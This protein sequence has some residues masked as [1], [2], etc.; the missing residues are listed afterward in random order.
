MNNLNSEI[1]KLRGQGLT[2]NFIVDELVKKG[3]PVEQ[4]NMALGQ[5]DFN[6]SQQP[7]SFSLPQAPEGN[8]D[9]RIE[10]IAE[11]I[12]DEKWDQLIV[13]VKKIIDWKE[14]VEEQQQKLLNDLTKL[15]EDFKTL[16]HG[17]L[18]KLE[19]YDSRM[20]EVGTELNAVG[21]VFKDVVPQFVENVKELSSITEK[22]R[23]K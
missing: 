3:Y 20:R 9:S 10:E 8:F 22:V 2:D 23:K 1:E 7:S 16:H 19:D 11:G 4:V 12:I 17:V 14:K 6:F 21:K 18:G 5:D 13:E 15:Q